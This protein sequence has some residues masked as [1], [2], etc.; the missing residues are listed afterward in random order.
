VNVRRPIIAVAGSMLLLVVGATAQTSSPWLWGPI[1][2]AIGDDRIV[3]SWETSRAVSVDLHYGLAQV[4]RAGGPW[5]ETLTFDWQEGRA[6]IWL[7]DLMPGTDYAFQL[8]AY[9]GDAVYPSKIGSFRTSSLADRAFSLAVYGHTASYPDLH[10]LVADAIAED[11]TG[12]AFAA[13]V[14]ELVESLTADRI[15][16]YLWAIE[17]LARSVPYLSVI[18]S[19]EE[20][21]TAYYET[22]A[23]PQG[24]GV[25]GEQWWSFDYGGIHVIGL[26]ASLTDPMQARTQEQ[27]AWLRGDLAARDAAFTIVLSSA[28]LYGSGHPGGR[29]ERLIAAWEAILRDG[30]VDLVLSAD[31]G[32]YE[33]IYAGG[34][35]HITTG[36]GGGPLAEAPDAR[37]PGLIFSRY[38]LLHYVR[39]TLAG[40]A[41]QLEAVPVASVIEDEVYLTP[42]ARPIDTLVLRAE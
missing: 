36:G 40:D 20:N 32:G 27:I 6:E 16:N 12:V 24:G 18:G 41:L 31:F 5:D 28:G 15:S 34:I 11:E 13:H 21:Q 14:G 8:I 33:H 25:S 1:L 37:P 29:N 39:V 9:E 17:E 23:L 4:Q 30:D 26:D 3:I 2:G 10:K 19:A 35:H 38:G 42:S 22:F 7:R